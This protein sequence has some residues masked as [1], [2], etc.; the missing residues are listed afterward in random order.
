VQNQA[1]G[2]IRAVVLGPVVDHKDESDGLIDASGFTD[3]VVFVSPVSMHDSNEAVARIKKNGNR[4]YLFVLEPKCKNHYHFVE[5]LSFLILEKGSQSADHNVRVVNGKS[6]WI[7]R[8]PDNENALGARP[9]VFQMIQSS[10]NGAH[11]T[12]RK[13]NRYKGYVKTR[14]Q[15]K[16][17]GGPRRPR[18]QLRIE[19]SEKQYQGHLETEQVGLLYFKS[20]CASN[21]APESD[22]DSWCGC[23][24]DQ[25]PC[26]V[27]Q[28]TF[29]G[30]RFEAGFVWTKSDFLERHRQGNYKSTTSVSYQ[31]TFEARPTLLVNMQ[32][33][34]GSEPSEVRLVSQSTTGFSYRID[35]D[36]C[37]NS[38]SRHPS[39]WVSYLAIEP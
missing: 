13:D 36:S 35:E 9:H 32:T 4:F 33:E 30:K 12:E 27:R 2:N 25:T 1:D 3:P 20:G 29:M 7:S 39:E 38:E 28:G 8:D 17:S 15:I 5:K 21:Q 26:L 19:G 37:G 11:Q 23:A 34:R 22:D 18:M 6:N 10:G 16:M 14:M 24:K 31:T